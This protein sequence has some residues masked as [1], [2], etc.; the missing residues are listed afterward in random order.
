MKAST[1]LLA[2]LLSSNILMA[3]TVDDINQLKL[4][5]DSIAMEY[6][7]RLKP[8]LK[9][10]IKTGG[11]SHAAKV[12]SVEAPK[13]AASLEKSTGWKIKRVSLQPRN[14]AIASPDE[15]EYAVLKQ[16]EEAVARKDIEPKLIQHEVVDNEF[17]Y[18]KAQRVEGI[19]LNC[20]GQTLSAD[21]AKTIGDLYPED[22]ATGYL[23]GQVRGAISLRMQLVN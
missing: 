20:H 2:L 18:L 10:A 11:L 21:V 19:C 9:T 17:R 23:L 13:I 7:S 16:F 8:Q 5:A 15:Y 12:C 3:E 4:E 1:F 6:A 22:T 14:A